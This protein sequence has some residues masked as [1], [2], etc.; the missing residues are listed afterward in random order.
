MEG[1]LKVHG[2]QATVSAMSSRASPQL[3]LGVA[4]SVM[5]LVAALGHGPGG[6]Q[7]TTRAGG[8]QMT[9]MTRAMAVRLG[10]TKDAKVQ[11]QLFKI[12]TL[13]VSLIRV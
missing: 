10:A 6:I 9:T 5:H 11:T 8:H 7:L 2:Y 13:S 3:R 4:N 12:E 1:P